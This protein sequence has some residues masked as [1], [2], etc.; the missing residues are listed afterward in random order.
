[1]FNAVMIIVAACVVADPPIP[2]HV[3]IIGMAIM[4]AEVVMLVVFVGIP[5]ILPRAV[6]RCSPV[7]VPTVIVMAVMVIVLSKCRQRNGEQGLGGHLKSGHLW[8]L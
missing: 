4:I 8:S 7:V 3:R 2:V 1:M 6:T 5:V